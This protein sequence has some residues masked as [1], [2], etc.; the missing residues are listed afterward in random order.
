MN[1]ELGRRVR[2][3]AKPR[4]EVKNK[5]V[6]KDID[7]VQYLKNRARVVPYGYKRNEDYPGWLEPIPLEIEAL[8]R[9]RDYIKGRCKYEDVAD[10]LFK[11][12]G[13]KI[14]IMGL[15]KAVR[16]GY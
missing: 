1:E 5:P 4:S 3:L 15:H 7:G 16:R 14:S 13:R 8:K 9:A 2:Y 6:F 11:A 12:T 10:W